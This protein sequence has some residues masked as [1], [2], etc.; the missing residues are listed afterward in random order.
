MNYGSYK[1]INKITD[2]IIWSK[3]SVRRI[4]IHTLTVKLSCLVSGWFSR[5][6]LSM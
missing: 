5:V 1:A 4:P 2:F 6:S 3:R